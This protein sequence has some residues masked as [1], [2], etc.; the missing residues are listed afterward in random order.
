M[1]RAAKTRAQATQTIYW[2][3]GGQYGPFAVQQDGEWAGWPNAGQVM[4]Y[5]RKKAKLSAKA[6]G[7]L[8]GRAV[9]A[10]GS[11]ICERW[12]LD[13]ELENKVPM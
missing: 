7:V 8:Y 1:T 13:M 4:R 2:G 6:F 12:V 3:E 10:D 9:N 11:P 5:F